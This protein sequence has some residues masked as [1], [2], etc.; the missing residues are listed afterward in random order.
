VDAD[1]EENSQPKGK[2]RRIWISIGII[3][4]LLIVF[5]RPILLATIHWF[6]VRAAAKEN[7]KLDFRLEGSVLG[8][9]TIRNLHITPLKPEAPV[10]SGDANY[11]RAEY[12]LFSLLGNKA[13][14]IE[15]IE[16][17]DAHFV[18]KPLPTVKPSPPP[19]EKTSLPAIFPRRVRI[20][21]VSVTVRNKPSDLVLEDFNLELNPRAPGALSVAK[22]QLPSGQ[23]WSGVTGTTSYTARNLFFRDIALGE[24]AKIPL[25]NLDASNIRAR[26]LGFKIDVA[27]DEASL[28]AQGQLMEEARSLRVKAEAAVHN[29]SLDSLQ[30][31]GVE[32]MAGKVENVSFDFSGLLSSPKT[33][34]SSGAALIKDLQSNGVTLDRI[35]AQFSAHDGVATI[36]PVEI[37][38]AGGALQARGNIELPAKADDLG[39]SSAHFEIAANN[40]DLAPITS[41]MAQPVS[42]RAQING[43]LDVRGERMDASLKIS[44]ASL[45][46][47][48]TGLEKL[49][50]AV[51]CAKDLRPRSKDASWFDGMQTSAVL[52]ASGARSGELTVDAISATIEQQQGEVAIKSATVR[53]G[54][55]SVVA[56]GTVQLQPNTTDFTKQ[57]AQ[58]SLNINAPQLADFW[59]TASPNRICGAL[60]GWA[61]VKWDGVNANGSFNVYGSGLQARNLTIPQ[62]NTA[63]SISGDTI[64]LNDLTASLNQRDYANAQGTFDWRGEKTFTGKLAIDIADLATLKPLLEAG[65]NKGE[66]AGSLTMNFEGTGSLSNL[67]RNG[68]LKLALNNGKFG[69]Q[70][71]LQANV[72]ATY[73]VAGLEVPTFFIGSDQM[74]VQA[75]VSAKGKTLEISK[76]Q[77]DQGTAKY[78]AGSMT[79]PFIWSHVGTSEPLFPSN[80]NVTATFQSENLDLKKMF[81]NFGMKPAAT[82]TMSVKF[83]ASGTLSDLRGRLDVDAR[84]L[85]SPQYANLEPATLRL[86]AEA[87]EKKFSMVGELK[88]AKIEPVAI[89]ATMPLDADKVLSTGSLDQN[90]P[91]NATV[92]LPRS[93]VNF[94]RQF[95][96]AIEQLDGSAALDVAVGGTIAHPVFSGSGDININVGRFVNQT[97]P[98]LTNYEGR[99]VFR[100]NTLTLEKFGGDLAGG[101]FKLGGRVVFTKLT[102]ANLDLNL[103]ADSV[104]VARNDSLTA[105]VDAN[106]KITGPLTGAL[107]KGDVALTNSHFLKNIDIIPIGLPGRPAPEPPSSTQVLSIPNPPLRDWK[108]DI[109]IKSKDPFLINGNLATGKAIIDMKLNGTGLHPGLQGQVRL[110]NF[111]A[112]LPFS[113]L[114]VQYGFL[115]FT[116]DDPLNPRIELRGTSLIR[117]YTVSVYVYGTSLA[118]EAVFSSEPPLPQEDIISLLATGTTRQEL[119]GSGN[120]LASRAALLLV[121]QLY[122]KF[123]KKGEPTKSDSFFSRLD[124][125]FTMA[126]ERTGRQSATATYKLTDSVVLVGDVGVAGDYRGLVKYLIRF[127]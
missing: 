79:I 102:E 93:S 14:L 59:A 61:Y 96:P 52:S 75:V 90:T 85:R 60:S 20:E 100:D 19:K 44:S 121:K 22:L 46:T 50:A 35:N 106:I 66:L 53:R 26:T 28:G 84:D 94:I 87:A 73:S 76:I 43:T 27:I 8:G 112:T 81:E 25:V 118:P 64:Y 77:L 21:G 82:G 65:G 6:A 11:I 115:Y 57:P 92:R 47:G 88:Q 122:T 3:L 126:D 95:V 78:A 67:T 72:D 13:D 1:Q 91:V 110:E 23:N 32:G 101:P 17:R 109:T 40:I 74:D 97:L 83:D 41:A 107:V 104:L 15:L 36:Q 63:G 105:R 71:G 69:N 119:T 7:L 108:F 80:G 86:T 24:R 70:K 49:E 31:F 111:D 117:D 12:D 58:V 103:R 99:L 16:V 33:W 68:S 45:Q 48:D 39:R 54:Q 2:R 5:H 18:I 125:G 37:A 38:R 62:L 120:V 51:S 9:I 116:P 56:S 4:A 30:Q 10:E 55:N 113:T 123:F 34:T 114:S 98:A 89:A 29:L 42:G 127:R 124:V